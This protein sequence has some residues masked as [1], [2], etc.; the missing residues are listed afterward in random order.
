MV[1]VWVRIWS[2][3]KGKTGRESKRVETNNY[4]SYCIEVIMIFLTTW[5]WRNNF[6]LHQSSTHAHPALL[7]FRWQD[8]RNHVGKSHRVG[9]KWW[10]VVSMGDMLRWIG[11]CYSINKFGLLCNSQAQ[12]ISAVFSHKKCSRCSTSTD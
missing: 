4:V 11:Y 12:S 7:Y 10:T 1:L 8:R 6:I 5:L 3:G 9:Q 2:L